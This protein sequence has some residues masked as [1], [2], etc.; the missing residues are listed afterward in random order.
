MSNPKSESL[1]FNKKITI[2]LQ[3][4]LESLGV[5]KLRWCSVRSIDPLGFFDVIYILIKQ[6]CGFSY[7][8]VLQTK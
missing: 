4:N 1:R 7:C 8:F 2:C 5:C 6:R 3:M